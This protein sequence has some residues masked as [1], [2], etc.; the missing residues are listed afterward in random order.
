MKSS[1]YSRFVPVKHA[2][3]RLWTVVLNRDRAATPLVMVH[4]MG[5]GLALWAQN[6]DELAHKRPVYM[7][8]LLGFG[9][10]SRPPFSQEAKITELE[11]VDSVE[12]WRKEVNL[13]SFILL[14]HS[15]GAFLASSYAIKHPERVKHLILVDPWGFPEKPPDNEMENRFPRWIRV[16]ATMLQPFNPLAG[17]RVAG[18]W[19]KTLG[20][21]PP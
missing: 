4:G 14:G 2:Q 5:G 6:M 11:F 17:L 18:P 16:I 10:S 3:S 7:F 8:D 12:D 19:G 15:L 9:R 20:K 1:I 13:D 21:T